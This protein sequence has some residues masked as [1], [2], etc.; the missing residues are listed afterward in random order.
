MRS[1]PAVGAGERHGSV[2]DCQLRVGP[3]RYSAGQ[4]APH[5]MMPPPQSTS[6]SGWSQVR[7]EQLFASVHVIVQ[8]APLVHVTWSQL[9]AAPQ[10]MS[11]EAPLLQ[12]TS[13]LLTPTQSTGQAMAAS[14]VTSQVLPEVQ[15]TAQVCGASHCTAQSSSPPAQLAV[16]MSPSQVDSQLEHIGPPAPVPAS[17]ASECES[18]PQPDKRRHEKAR[19]MKFFMAD[20]PRD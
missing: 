10:S 1:R 18:S 14:Q 4:S 20:A 12:P 2:H 5:T 3:S 11:Q 13:Q 17:A 7:N 6:P 19:E 16:H 9:L 8:L 15:P